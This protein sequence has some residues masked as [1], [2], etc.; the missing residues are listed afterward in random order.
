[1]PVIG[2]DKKVPLVGEIAKAPDS[3]GAGDV[4]RS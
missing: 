3:V 2:Y 1:M 4:K